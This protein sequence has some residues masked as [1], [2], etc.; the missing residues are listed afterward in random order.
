VAL[1]EFDTLHPRASAAA[2]GNAQSAAM[3][4]QSSAC[5]HYGRGSAHGTE[6]H[7]TAHGQHGSD[8]YRGTAQRPT[9]L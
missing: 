9:V 1:C 2:S 7:T 3:R 8:R 4:R 5:R 6:G